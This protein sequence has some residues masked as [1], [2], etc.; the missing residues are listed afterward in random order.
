MKVI[1]IILH[2]LVLLK[3]VIIVLLVVSFWMLE[4]VLLILNYALNTPL[5]WALDKIEKLI[6]LLLKQ[7]K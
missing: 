5:R 2:P 3:L 6:K 1:K 7:I 4:S